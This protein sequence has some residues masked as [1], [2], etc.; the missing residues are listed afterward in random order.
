MATFT[1]KTVS[2]Q[3]DASS[4][5]E[6]IAI[7]FP[8]LVD[9]IQ[10]QRT[11]LVAC[12]SLLSPCESRPPGLGRQARHRHCIVPDVTIVQSPNGTQSRDVRVDRRGAST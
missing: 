11:L 5:S 1:Q 10:A 8:F 4:T 9:G 3:L 2:P 12:W 6:G 7:A